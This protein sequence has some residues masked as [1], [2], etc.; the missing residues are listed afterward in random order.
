MIREL[1][2]FFAVF[3]FFSNVLFAQE[4]DS[5]YRAYRRISL[6][7]VEQTKDKLALLDRI[8]SYEL[9]RDPAQTHRLIDTFMLLSQRLGD[10]ASY[11]RARYQ[12]RGHLYAVQRN[13]AEALRHYLEYAKV[14][15]R[16]DEGDGYFLIDVGNIYYNLRLY[17]MARKY[18]EEAEAVFTNIQSDKGLTTVYG[19]Y[20][21]VAK[22]KNQI[23]SA[24]YYIEK[25]LNLQKTSVKDSFQIAHSYQLLGWYTAE[26]RKDYRTALAYYQQALA[27]LELPQ[28]RPN[29][30]YH[31]FIYLLPQTYMRMG[32]AYIALS[33]PD[34]AAFFLDKAMTE[35]RA[36]GQERVLTMIAAQTGEDWLQLNQYDKALGLLL[37]AE[38]RALQSSN[39]LD[40]RNSYKQL[41]TVYTALGQDRK[42]LEYA[43]KYIA[44][45]DSMK[46]EEDQLLWMNDQVLQL[47]RKQT[48]EQQQRT[49]R[50]EQR[51]RMGLTVLLVLLAVFVVFVGIF[52]W[53]MRQQNRL[54]RRYNREL[55]LADT[56]KERILMVVGHDLRSLFGVLLANTQQMVLDLQQNDRT[57][58]Q[59]DADQL[60]QTAKKAY[61]MMDGLMQWSV[62]QKETPQA[63][64]Q[65]ILLQE[66]TRSTTDALQPIF[67]MSRVALSLD[68]PPI[69]L[70]SDANLLQIVLRNLLTNAVKHSPA[71]ETVTVRTLAIDEGIALRV[72]DNGLGLDAD[73]LRQLLQ[74]NTDGVQQAKQGR[75]LG[76]EIVQQ[77]CQAMGITLR[78]FNKTQGS[79][80]VFELVLPQAQFLG[81]APSAVV[82]VNLGNE[83][84]SDKERLQL[85]PLAHLL[86]QYE[87]YE[88]TEIQNALQSVRLEPLTAAIRLWLDELRRALTLNDEE[89]YARVLAR[90]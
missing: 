45:N 15:G 90:V 65:P 43:D 9:Y 26:D 30:H 67:E 79:G 64:Q 82:S 60:T 25:T 50:A 52:W 55:E 58:L 71:N 27:L 35:A 57:R 46:K 53:K 73:I 85:Q 89:L 62:L 75:G 40:L 61:M 36:L 68:V 54:I 8:I 56:I 20:S 3:C 39:Q 86:R 13:Q 74:G 17:D 77:L 38:Q 87:V 47:E 72:E 1:S 23:D 63:Q 88:R 49:I 42:A 31:H 84:L 6:N 44:L 80:A 11:N 28:L 21:L 81:K 5:L 83:G 37:E 14:F 16:K 10:Q 12:F 18:Y 22:R 7:D 2:L 78:A 48:I 4:L 29:P 69:S 66:L 70:V 41:K 19:N 51:L 59:K 24:F 32:R 34:S 76:L 33:Q